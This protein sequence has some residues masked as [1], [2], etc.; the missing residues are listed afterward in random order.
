MLHVVSKKI[1]CMFSELESFLKFTTAINMLPPKQIVVEV[2]ESASIFAST[3]L[4]KLS[5]P[6]TMGSLDQDTF[7]SCICAAIRQEGK[8]FTTF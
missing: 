3:C 4:M 2:V 6:V 8:S 5:L 7:N 1:N